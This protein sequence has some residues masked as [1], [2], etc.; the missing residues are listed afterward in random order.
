M[1]AKYKILLLLEI[2]VFFS[3]PVVALCGMAF[4]SRITFEEFF[5]SKFIS[6]GSLGWLIIVIGGTLGLCAI[7]SML[8]NILLPLNKYVLSKKVLILF[9]VI[10]FIPIV[11]S[12]VEINNARFYLLMVAPAFIG[13]AHLVYLNRYY[14]GFLSNKNQRE[15]DI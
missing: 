7:L 2:I 5:S 11:L 9:I 13:T 6:N 8:L 1:K 10:G 4:Y 14:F 12:A 15:A 3:F